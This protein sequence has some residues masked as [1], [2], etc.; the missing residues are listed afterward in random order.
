MPDLPLGCDGRSSNSRPGA[1][2]ATPF[3]TAGDTMNIYDWITIARAV[4]DLLYL[5]AAIITLV[6]AFGSRGRR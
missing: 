6:V 5:V 2:P 4:G 1:R 3:T